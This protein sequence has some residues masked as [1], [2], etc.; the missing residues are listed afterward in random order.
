MTSLLRLRLAAAALAV[1]AASPL[2]AG[3][4]TYE[5]RPTWLAAITSL[6]NYDFGTGGTQQGYYTSNGFIP[7]SNLQIIGAIGSGFE[8]YTIN[9]T[10]SPFYNWNS[11][12]IGFSA[13]QTAVNSATITINFMGGPVNSFGINL[14]LGGSGGGAGNVTVTPQGM[15]A[16]TVTTFN[17]ATGLKFFGVTSDTQTFNSV[18]LTITDVNRYIVIDDISTGSFSGSGGG[19][20]GGGSQETPEAAT[21]I[22]VGTGLAYLGY[23]RRNQGLATA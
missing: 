21:L 11:G 17:Q 1:F 6:I 9:G 5:D 3:T 12:R 19:G 14:G 23:R 10:G 7:N 16:Q 18:T 22:C 13:A 2:T 15:A 4:V 8:F 20:G